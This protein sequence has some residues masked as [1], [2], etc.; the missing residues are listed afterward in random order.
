METINGFKEKA[1]KA[2]AD[3]NS[4]EK[5]VLETVFGKKTFQSVLER[6]TTFEEA[7]LETGRDP[8]DPFFSEVRPHEN[9]N[10][11]IEEVALALNEGKVLSLSDSS[12]EK[13]WVYV[14]RDNSISGFRLYVVVYTLTATRAGLGSR[15]AFASE[16]KANHFAKHFMPLINESLA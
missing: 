1:I 12:T 2:H 3:G 13:W 4:T 5:N 7:C 11:K 15:L 16:K 6:V 8:N 10:R 14:I 9:A